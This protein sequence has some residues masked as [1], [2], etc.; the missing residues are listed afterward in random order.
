MAYLLHQLLSES[1]RKYPDKIAL[2]FKDQTLTYAQLD[3]ETNRL[4]NQLIKLGVKKD[5]RVSIYLDKSFY[6][7]ISVYGILKAGA[8]Y[9]PIDPLAPVKYINYIISKC[10]ITSLITFKEK[11]ENIEKAFPEESPLENIIIMN[12]D[13][14]QNL[15]SVQLINWDEAKRSVS[16]GTPNINCIEGELAYILFT[17]GSTGDP[18]GVMISHRNSLT[19]VDS[20]HDF[21]EI[22]ENDVLSNHPPLHFD[23]SVFDIF[24]AAKAGATLVIVPETTSMF[25]TKIAEFVSDNKITV[26]NSVPSVLSLLATHSQLEEYDFSNLRVIQFAGEVFPIKYLR[27]LKEIISQAK[28]YNVYG[29]TE[30]NS[31]TFYLIEKLPEND[32]DPIPIG[33]NFPNFNVFAIDDDGKEIT[34]PGEKGEFYVNAGSVAYGYWN[35]PERTRERFVNNPLKPY[36]EER[37]Y[38]T[39]DVVTLDSDGNYIF[40]GRK[41]HMIKSRGY[42]VE[43]GQI[44]TAILNH[45]NVKDA[46]VIP[47]PDELIGNRITAVVVP[48]V[49]NG[50]NKSDIV[51]HCSKQLPRYMIPEN[52][53]FSDSLPKTSSGKTDRRR[54]TEM[55]SQMITALNNEG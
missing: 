3:L 4:A 31:S 47:I 48:V 13:S 50:I 2:V 35:D 45:P 30:A 22:R 34:K 38:R 14:D 28:Y 17:S 39:G 41:D 46:V 43:I 52:I 10:K 29:Q 11:I 53:E 32:T 40:V 8:A 27:R 19:Y 55:M 5:D 36:L 21:F 9:V 1:A 49:Q 51:K 24:C 16:S 7:I 23:M 33:K 12:G 42:R 15:D 6:S 44:E 54:L 18:K 25:P 26:W 37:V 20:T